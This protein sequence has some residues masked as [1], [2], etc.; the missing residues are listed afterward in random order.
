MFLNLGPNVLIPFL[1]IPIF[2]IY[3]YL[4]KVGTWIFMLFS[5]HLKQLC[6]FFC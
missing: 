3:H 2:R 4:V 1:I 5:I 6:I